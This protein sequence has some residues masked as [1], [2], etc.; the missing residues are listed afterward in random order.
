M[1]EKLPKKPGVKSISQ[2]SK[3]LERVKEC[4]RRLANVHAI[5]LGWS[6]IL[7]KTLRHYSSY[8]RSRVQ[9][10]EFDNMTHNLD[11]FYIM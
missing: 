6:I 4:L 9:S 1:S 10:L 3:A 5:A 7:Q 8:D 2:C 11:K